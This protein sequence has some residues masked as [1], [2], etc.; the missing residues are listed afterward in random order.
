MY[1]VTESTPGYLPES[2][3]IMC[4]DLSDAIM[5]GIALAD[6]VAD[7]CEDPITIGTFIFGGID[8]TAHQHVLVLD[9]AREHDLGRVICIDRID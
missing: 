9:N 4:E 3:P 2:D 5:T 6:Q 8:V 1:A 7:M